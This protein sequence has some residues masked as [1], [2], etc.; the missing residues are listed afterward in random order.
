MMDNPVM[1]GR[2][3]GSVVLLIRTFAV[4]VEFLQLK[5][6]RLPTD[7]GAFYTGRQTQILVALGFWFGITLGYH[8]LAFGPRTSWLSNWMSSSQGGGSFALATL[9]LAIPSAMH[10]FMLSIQFSVPVTAYVHQWLPSLAIA[11]VCAIW[12]ASAIRETPKESPQYE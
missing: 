3:L 7:G 4:G 12:L 1:D 5:G 10:S 8:L 11:V 9:I 6:T 2:V